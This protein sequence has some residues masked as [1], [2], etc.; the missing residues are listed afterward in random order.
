MPA[1]RPDAS[2]PLPRKITRL[3]E[4]RDAWKAK[5][6]LL[7]IRCRVLE[8]QVRAVEQ[9]RDSWRQKLR[10]HEALEKS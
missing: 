7:M 4:S 8:N 6:K 3:T 5:Y 10:H 1:S 2:T 9:S